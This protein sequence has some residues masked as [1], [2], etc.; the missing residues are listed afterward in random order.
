LNLNTYTT[1]IKIVAF[2][3]KHLHFLPEMC[4]KRPK[5]IRCIPRS[6]GVPS[7]NVSLADLS[8]PSWAKPTNWA[9][10]A[11]SDASG[12]GNSWLTGFMGRVARFYFDTTHQ[13]GENVPKYPEYIPNG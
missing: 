12:C 10:V 3:V 1:A 7:F 4:G 8:L 9:E 5:M 13:N 6:P 2:F 11:K